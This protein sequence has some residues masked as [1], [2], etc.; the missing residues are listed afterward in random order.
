MRRFIQ[1][2]S[3]PKY[4]LKIETWCPGIELKNPPEWMINNCKVRN[5]ETSNGDVIQD[6]VQKTN[7][8]F[9]FKRSDNS[10]VN[11]IT[12]NTDDYVCYGDNRL[13]VLRQSQ[14][15]L[16]YSEWKD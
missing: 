1:S 7:G 16:L 12:N 13:F 2:G 11:I 5:I 6:Y 9:E 15:D 3:N 10:P 8:G 4:P 14:L